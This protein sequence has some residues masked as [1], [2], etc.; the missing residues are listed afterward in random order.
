MAKKIL[1]VDDERAIVRLIQARLEREGYEIITA[2][3]RVEALE[4]VASEKPDLICLDDKMPRMDGFK[5]M[6]VLQSDPAKKDIPVIMVADG[7]RD[8][9]VFKGWRSG[10]MSYLTKPCKPEEVVHFV[11]K[12]LVSLQMMTKRNS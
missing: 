12:I 3:D 5:V 6:E 7:A 9:D 10:I 4:K 1:V 2:Y 11:N 8:A